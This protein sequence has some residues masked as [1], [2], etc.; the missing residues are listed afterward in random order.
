[1][2]V[3][4]LVNQIL[5]RMKKFRVNSGNATFANTGKNNVLDKS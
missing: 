1:M 3:E 4:N 2:K 5:F